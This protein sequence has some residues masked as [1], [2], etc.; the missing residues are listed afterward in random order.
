M[1]QDG[2]TKKVSKGSGEKIDANRFLELYRGLSEKAEC[3]YASSILEVFTEASCDLYQA[4]VGRTTISL[5]VY[6][7]FFTL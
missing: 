4:F 7:V 2:R 3:E 1:V 6:K 5:F